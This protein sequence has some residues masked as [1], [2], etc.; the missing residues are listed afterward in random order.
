MTKLTPIRVIIVDDHAVVQSGLSAFLSAFDDLELVG[1]AASG[2]DAVRLCVQTKPDVVLMDLVMPGMDGV[3]A[4]SAIRERC[5]NTKVIALT[6]FGDR[7]LVQA[8]LKAGAIG[9]LLKDVSVEELVSAIRN[10][11][12]GRPSL[13]PEATIALIQAATESSEVELDRPISPE[14]ITKPSTAEAV[15][16]ALEKTMAGASRQIQQVR[17]GTAISVYLGEEIISAKPLFWEPKK[18]QPRKLTNPHVLI[19]GTSGSGKTQTAMAFLYE[20]WRQRIPS[21]ILDFQGEYAASNMDKFRSQ[22]SAE[23]VDALTGLPMNPLDV[24]L[25]AQDKPDNYKRVVWEISEIIG[26]IF[27]LGLQ[28]KRTLKKM[29]EIAYQ[30]AGFTVDS[31]TWNRKPPK[32]SQ[33]KQILESRAGEKGGAA[34]GLLSRI[35]VLFDTET[36]SDQASNRFEDLIGKVTVVDLSRLFSDEHRLLVARFF[37][38]KV[39][40]HMLL[41]GESRDPKLFVVIDEAHRLSYDEALLRLIREARKYGIGILLSSQQPSD[42][43][44]TAIELPGT[45]V[46]L[47][48]GPSAARRLSSYLEP[49]DAKRRSKIEDELEKLEIGQAFI[50]SDHFLPY[51]KARMQLFHE[52]LGK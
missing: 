17:G 27:H 44:N 26:G 35:E 47:Q 32:F 15:D 16:R 22:T 52:R 30:A 2:E 12:T 18:E 4:T 29:I 6:S 3:S 40:N 37:L 13:S 49:A 31:S 11:V 8:V 36:F 48:Q 50:K 43:P 20:T 38:Q 19:V 33:L 9:Y 7:K 28:Q 41:K 39:Y 46:F 42:F 45:K 23:V 51:V 21:V 25:D 1:V 14:T 24:P 34:A 5:P 10:A